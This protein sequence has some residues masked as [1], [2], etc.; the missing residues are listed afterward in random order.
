MKKI[1][2]LLVLLSVV[3]FLTACGQSGGLYLPAKQSSPDPNLK[4]EVLDK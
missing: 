2:T 1:I 4:V 3:L